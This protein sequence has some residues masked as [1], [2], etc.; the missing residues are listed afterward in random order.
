MGVTIFTAYS[1]KDEAIRNALAN[2]LVPLQR[3]GLV[4]VWHDR[5]IPAGVPLDDTISEQLEAADIVLLLV[6]SD[7][8][9]SEYCW[10]RETARALERCAKGQ[11]VVIP[12]IVR[13]CDWHTAPF[14]SLRAT[15]TDGLPIIGAWQDADFAMLTVAKDVR[16][17]VE[18]IVADRPA[19]SASDERYSFTSV[20]GTEDYSPNG[21]AAIR[22]NHVFRYKAGRPNSIQLFVSDYAF[23]GVSFLVTAA[24]LDATGQLLPSMPVNLEATGGSFGYP[25]EGI[26]GTEAGGVFST[27]IYPH[28]DADMVLITAHSP[29]YPSVQYGVRVVQP[30]I[31][32][33]HLDGG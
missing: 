22:L 27:K 33:P 30:P 2:H 15:P 23:K 29:G 13:Y 1:H 10:K 24:V 25:S 19:D 18:R 20:Y 31:F 5:R 11:A 17:V 32:G 3:E 12:V 6:S 8:M 28:D 9:A 14:A 16:A 21:L 4:E 26:T 7:F